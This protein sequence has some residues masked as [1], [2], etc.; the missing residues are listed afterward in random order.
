MWV[1]S[2]RREVSRVGDHCGE[3]TLM[4]V[5]WMLEEGVAYNFDSAVPGTG[6][7]CV[8][9]YQIPMYSKDFPIMLL[10]ATNRKLI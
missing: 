2:V 8:L 1:G 3:G 6:A 7:E 10:P 5:R 4:K 9:R